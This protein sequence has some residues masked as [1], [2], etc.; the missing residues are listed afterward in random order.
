MLVD[1]R[2]FK[3]SWPGFFIPLLL[4]GCAS[5]GVIPMGP[6]QYM[7]AKKDGTPGLGVSYQ[8]KAEVYA[9]ATAFCASQGKVLDVTQEKLI[10]AQ[11]ARLGSTEITFRCLQGGDEAKNVISPI[12]TYKPSIT[13]APLANTLLD[14]PRLAL[15]IGNADYRSAPLKNPVSDVRGMEVAL[16]KAG[17]EVIRRENLDYQQMLKAI[18]D[19][20]SRLTQDHVSLV[21]YSG[22]GVQVKGTNYLIPVSSDLKHEDEVSSL[23]I[24]ADLLLNKLKTVNSPLNIVVLDA[25]RDSPLGRSV[26]AASRGLVSMSAARGTLIAFSTSPG[27]V[28]LDGEG[29]NSPYTKHLIDAIQTEGILLEQ[30]F[31]VVRN[32]VLNETNGS[33]VPWE[34]S[35]ILGDFYFVPRKDIK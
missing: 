19:F 23:A 33:Q 25:C 26:R 16:K 18:R 27:E 28:A 7:I 6:N 9:E 4:S 31:K 13:S 24:S 29:V 22:H 10:P 35:S 3:W 14:R 15:L 5:T 17:F 11:L 12:P 32:N 21:Y 1:L 34:N 8:N 2:L 30:V 20:T